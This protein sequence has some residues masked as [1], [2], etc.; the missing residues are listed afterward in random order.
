ML[1][2]K[3]QCIADRVGITNLIEALKADLLA[4]HGVTSVEFDLDGFL[5]NLNQ[6]IFLTGYDIP[7]S[8]Y[9]SDRKR[10]IESIVSTAA[11]HG[12]ART[13]DSIEDYGAHLY[14]VFSCYK[15]WG[16]KHP[17]W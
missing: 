17:V 15:R 12:L 2:E 7:L 5:D 11:A 8:S 4:I 13:G 16:V 3:E 14:F 1:H 9:F 6:V 10:M